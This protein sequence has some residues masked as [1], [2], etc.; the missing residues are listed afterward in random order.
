MEH[1]VHRELAGL[2][3]QVVRQ[4][5]LVHQVRVARQV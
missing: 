5:V 3:V 4:E 1:Q 2:Q